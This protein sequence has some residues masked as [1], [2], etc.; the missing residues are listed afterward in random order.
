MSLKIYPY[1]FDGR[2]DILIEDHDGYQASVRRLVSTM[3]EPL[4]IDLAQLISMQEIP[5]LVDAFREH[6][7]AGQ[8]GL[9]ST[10]VSLANTL[11]LNSIPQIWGVGL[12]F[13]AHANDLET[14][15]PTFGPGSYLRPYSCVIPNGGAIEIP[16]QSTRVTAEGELGLVLGKPCRNVSAEEA[17]DY[18]LGFTTILD[19]T[20]EDA[21]RKNPRYIPWSKGFDTFSSI[22]PCLVLRDQEQCE[23]IADIT[24]T[25]YLNG[26]VVSHDSVSAMKYNPAQLVEYFSAGR[27]LP[28][29]TVLST[30][31]PGA[32]VIAPG[33]TV[34]AEVSGIGV[35]DHPVKSA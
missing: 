15:Q 20:A 11:L 17:F 18:V 35:L 7:A 32:T 4:P 30:G 14:A 34:R 28:A 10:P 27:T 23:D 9:H 26:S 22:G 19:M 21:I 31:T 8:E 6:R 12:N 16:R 1:S 33:D 25:T 29:G 2:P 24:V 5:R 3:A 13:A